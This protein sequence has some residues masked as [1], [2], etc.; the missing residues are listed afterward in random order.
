MGCE[1]IEREFK[2]DASRPEQRNTGPRGVHRRDIDLEAHETTPHLEAQKRSSNLEAQ[3]KVTPRGPMQ[4][5]MEDVDKIN[6][7]PTL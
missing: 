2:S 7:T 1:S 6:P 3:K 4:K 5:K